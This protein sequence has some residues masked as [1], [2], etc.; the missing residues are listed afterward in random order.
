MSREELIPIVDQLKYLRS[1]LYIL[2]RKIAKEAGK[3]E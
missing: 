1:E 3:P 2:T